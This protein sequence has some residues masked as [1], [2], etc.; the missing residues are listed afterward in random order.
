MVSLIVAM[1]AERG[2][3][4]NNALPW[5]YPEDLRFFQQV[6]S[7]DAG[8]GR[9]PVVIMGRKTRESLPH[10]PLPG[11]ENVVL[12]R[13]GPD[14][15]D[16]LATYRKRGDVGRI[17]VIGGGEIYQQCMEENLCDFI[18]VTH[19][20]GTHD[21]DTFFPLLDEE[22]YHCLGTYPLGRL[23]RSMFCGVSS[24]VG[25]RNPVPLYPL[26]NASQHP[27]EQPAPTDGQ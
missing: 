27:H 21:C 4:R 14:L 20:P 11:R 23:T 17:T 12:S 10:F 5:H 16:V 7:H 8:Q 13:N 1:D 2:I 6:T 24:E 3:G 19:I 22:R 18:Y 26:Q 25:V 15:R 9:H